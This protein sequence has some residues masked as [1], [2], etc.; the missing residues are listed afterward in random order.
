MTKKKLCKR[1]RLFYTEDVCPRCHTADTAS[2]YQGKINII[3]PS[4]SEIAKKGGYNEQG[5]YAIKCR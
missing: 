2:S 1:D 5:E 3:D 4:K